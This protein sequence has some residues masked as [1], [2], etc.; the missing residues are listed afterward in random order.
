MIDNIDAIKASGIIRHIDD[1]GRVVIPKEIRRTQRWR[2]GDP[3]EI[4]SLKNGDV[5]LRKYSHIEEIELLSS[6]AAKC[7]SSMLNNISVLV[8]DRTKAISGVG[9]DFSN[10]VGHQ[11]CD[12]WMDKI[13]ESTGPQLIQPPIPLFDEH[14][15]QRKT[16]RSQALAP[17]IVDSSP[18][19]AVILVSEKR[20]LLQRDLIAAE[21]AARLIASNLES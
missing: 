18:I 12:W 5:L 20:D 7:L 4:L 15:E 21:T 19:G 1:L 16:Y 8:C 13:I 2:E 17:I 3:I 10:L 14:I 11:V 6:Y 9:K